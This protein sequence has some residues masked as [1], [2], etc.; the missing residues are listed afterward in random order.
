MVTYV[1]FVLGGFENHKDVEHFSVK[2]L[3]DSEIVDN[4]KYVIE[5]IPNVVIVFDSEL[6]Q[7]KLVEDLPIY[8]IPHG[9]KF[10]FL[11]RMSDTLSVYLPDELREMMFKPDEFRTLHYSE[12]QRPI[13]DHI[14]SLDMILDK[15]KTFGIESLT[16]NEKIFLDN[17][18]K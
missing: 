10:Y 4:V 8:T 11:F 1:L 13:E 12:K 17:F 7:K 2:V 18:N 15:I 9:I 6:D 16:D 14:L 3:G 5:S